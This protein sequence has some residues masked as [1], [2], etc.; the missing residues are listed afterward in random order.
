MSLEGN[1]SDGAADRKVCDPQRIELALHVKANARACARLLCIH[2]CLQVRSLQRLDSQRLAQR[3]VSCLNV[4]KVVENARAGHVPVL[5]ESC[6]EL[7]SLVWRLSLNRP[8][9]SQQLRVR[10]LHDLERSAHLCSYNSARLF[11]ML[12]HRC[13]HHRT[14]HRTRLDR[15]AQRHVGSSHLHQLGLGRRAPFGRFASGAARICKHVQRSIDVLLIEVL[16]VY[17]PLEHAGRRF[18]I[19]DAL[20]DEKT[21]GAAVVAHAHDG[22]HTLDVVRLHQPHHLF[23]RGCERREARERRAERLRPRKALP[24]LDMHLEI[25]VLLDFLGGCGQQRTVGPKR[26]Q[27]A[28]DA[29]H[30]VRQSG[31]RAREQL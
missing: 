1:P 17:G 2:D 31:P 18:E 27:C 26:N 29:L 6:R 20:V 12:L 10:R 3:V 21:Q 22:T 16:G 28:L 11:A 30:Q 8:A 14:L 4:D 15:R 5:L 24:D 7:L 25:T 19:A 13:L 23:V 9:P